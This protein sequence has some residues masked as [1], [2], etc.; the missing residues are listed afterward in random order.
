MRGCNSRRY[1]M[2]MLAAHTSRARRMFATLVYGAA[3]L[4]VYGITNHI[5][6]WSPRELPLVWHEEAIP[7]I[8]STVWVYLSV[9]IFIPLAFWRIPEKSLSRMFRGALI[10]L[11]IHGLFFLLFPTTVPR[12]PTSDAAGFTSHV[13]HH[14]AA[15]DR[16]Q[17]C[18]PSHHVAAVV[19]MA[20]ALWRTRYGKLFMAWATL[21]SLST[22]TTK[23]HIVLDVL[24]GIA[25]ATT[26]Y[27]LAFR[28]SVLYKESSGST[29]ANT[30]VT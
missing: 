4:F 17:N 26:V 21:I 9:F 28:T 29:S 27:F 16:P 23:Q 24:G 7:F 19:F 11:S 25:A 10:L 1:L 15:F 3:F 18:F 6:L 8:L 2:F 20:F 13:Y 22:L 5:L 12:V 30:Y 14:L